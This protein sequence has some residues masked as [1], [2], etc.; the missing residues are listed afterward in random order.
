M[1]SLPKVDLNPLHLHFVL[2]LKMKHASIYSNTFFGYISQ[3]L[4]HPFL[5]VFGLVFSLGLCCTVVWPLAAC[6]Y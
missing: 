1:N 4:K 5:A 6:G 3:L 2:K